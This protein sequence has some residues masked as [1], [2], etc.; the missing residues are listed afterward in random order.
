VTYSLP[1]FA[2]YGIELEYAIVDARSL[3]IRPLAAPLLRAMRG[4]HRA[5]LEGSAI[6]WSNE[7]VQHVVEIKNVAPVP[8][9]GPLVSAFRDAVA[10]ADR[11]IADYDAR[12]MPTGM[13][14]WMDAHAADLWTLDGSDVYRAFDRLFDCRQH[15]WANL[16]S[17]HINLPFANDLEFARLHAAVR[18]VLPLIPAIAASSP[19][20][21]GRRTPFLDYRLEVY[22]TSCQDVPTITGA[23]IPENVCGRQEYIRNVLEPMYRDVAANDPGGV[24]QHEWLNARGAI[25]RFD[26]NA[27]EIRLCDTQECPRADLAIA[28]LLAAVVR[29]L[30]E[31]RWQPQATQQAMKTSTLATLL[32]A[33]MRDADQALIADADYLRLF[34]LHKPAVRAGDI[35]AHLVA[36]CGDAATSV[37][38]AYREPIE[39]IMRQ[40][41]LARR[42]LRVLDGATGRRQLAHV[43]RRLCDCLAGDELFF[44]GA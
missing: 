16:Q 39:T 7:L 27:I 28:A 40:G 34:G 20:A 30:Y 12:L 37:D 44:A 13:H 1:A 36:E 19:F 23:V 3:D 15:G 8:S 31:E 29:A 43:Y 10:D 42:I 9:L 24:L 4:A 17:M 26:R 5:P 22:R 2:G 41:P 14:P 33:G 11:R 32:Q 38:P 21:D 35:W 18:V 25:A 6:G